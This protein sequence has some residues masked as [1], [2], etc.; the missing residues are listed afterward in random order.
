MWKDEASVTRRIEH[1]R[2]GARCLRRAALVAF[3]GRRRRELHRAADAIDELADIT[4]RE[5][6]QP[7]DLLADPVSAARCVWG[8]RIAQSPRFPW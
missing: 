6:P 2:E 8:A 4:E 3:E 7:Q 5:A 1:W